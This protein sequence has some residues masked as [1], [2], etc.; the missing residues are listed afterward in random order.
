MVAMEPVVTID[1]PSGAG[2]SSVARAVAIRGSWRYLD[3]GSLY[4]AITFGL[5]CAGLEAVEQDRAEW[6]CHQQEDVQVAAGLS[7]ESPDI[8]CNGTEVGIEI[9]SDLVTR[10]VSE[11]SALPCIRARLLTLQREV[12]QGGG[13]VV[14]GRDIGSVVWPAAE[15][16]I[17]LT[18]DLQARAARRH[19]EG[20]SI[21]GVAHVEAALAARDRI[22]STRDVSPLQMAPGALFIDATDLTLE[23]VV[24]RIWI[25]IEGV[26]AT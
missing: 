13:I 5:L 15:V 17:Y 3:T 24:D 21:A 9:R 2:K 25:E 1:G 10:Y 8:Y 14:E 16:K 22:D 4:R 18:A 19:A 23:E 7:P 20:A 26:R 6:I 11:V 12:I